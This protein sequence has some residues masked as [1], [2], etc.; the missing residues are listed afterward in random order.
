MTEVV[1]AV[2]GK[3]IAIT[4]AASGI[5]EALARCFVSHGAA[6]LALTDIN[7]PGAESLATQL[8]QEHD[9]PVFVNATDVSDEAQMVTFIDNAEAAVGP[10]DLFCGN[11][12]IF[13]FGGPEATNADWDRI[14]GVNVMAHVYA[15]RVLVPRMLARGGG[16]FML[17]VSAAGILTQI[18]SAPYSVTKAA[19][20]SFAE[21]L[22]ITYGERGLTVHAL[23]PQAVATAMTAGIDGGGVAGVDGMLSADDVA[24]AALDGLATGALRILPHPEVAEYGRRRADDNERWL[25]GMRRLQAMFNDFVPP[26]PGS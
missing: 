24:S 23:C 13:V 9:V 25:R 12:G 14:M 22:S 19:A 8:Q 7:G 3:V 6:A 5:G 18:G 1:H 26:V 10:L 17:T 2:E 4:G 16:T 15:S 11:A 20:L 21:W